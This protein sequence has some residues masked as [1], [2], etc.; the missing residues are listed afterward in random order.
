MSYKIT[1]RQT[2]FVIK[3]DII[4][5]LALDQFPRICRFWIFVFFLGKS[6]F[7]LKN[8]DNVVSIF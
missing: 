3:L 1:L 5:T 6:T 2:I 8:S 7:H 4:F